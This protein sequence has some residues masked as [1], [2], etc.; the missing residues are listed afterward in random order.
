M[1]LFQ[2]TLVTSALP[3]A[4]GY[5][6]LGHVAG[7][8]LPAD[9]YTRFL[10]ATGQ[11]VIHISGS[12]EHGVA[13]MIS[14]EEEKSTPQAIVDKYHTA[15]A[16]A[17]AGLGIAFDMYGRT[18]WP[19]H[20]QSAQEFFLALHQQ[21]YLVEKEEEQFYD[22][23][24]AMFLPDRYVEGTCPVCGALGARGDQCDNC[25]STYNQTELKNPISKLTGK[26]PELRTTRHFYFSLGK[27]QQRLEEYVEGHSHDWRDHVLQQS[28]SW[29][30]QGLG[31]RAITR[32]LSWGIDVPLAGYDGKKLYVW[33][34]APFGYITNTKVLMESRGD[35]NGWRRWWQSPDTRYVAFIGKD[36]IWFHTLMFPAMLMGWNDQQREQY[37]LPNNVPA[38]NFLNL[39][40]NKFSKSRKWGID[41]QDYLAQ[42]P[43]DPLRYTLAANLPENKDADFTWRE[44]Q[45]R[46]NNELA[47]ILGNFVNRTLQFSARYFDGAVPPLSP[48]SAKEE[49]LLSLLNED[50]RRIAADGRTDEEA[51]EELSTKYLNYL[52]RND[53]VMLVALARAP[54]RI[55][56]LYSA[57]RFRDA[58]LETMNVARAANKY[59]N[60]SEPWKTRKDNPER[61]ATSLNICLQVVRSLAVLFRPIIP[62]TSDQIFGL[63]NVPP[64]ENDWYS[65][66]TLAIPTTAPLAEPV[67]LFSKV[68][69]AVVEA[70]VAKLGAAAESSGEKQPIHVELKPEVTIEDVMKLDLR[71]AT[72]LAAERVKKSEKLLK[73]Q[74]RIGDLQRQILA[75]IGKVYQPEELVGKKIV[76]V[77]NLKPAKLMGQESQGMLFAANSPDD[78]PT[79]VT[80]LHPDDVDDGFIVR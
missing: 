67:I 58:A 69:D 39:E 29:L 47:D 3:Y 14:A 68:E 37:I 2:R 49:S 45:A 10:R 71:V 12:D 59:F 66:G 55:A 60:D 51:I 5:I 23:E 57:F 6:H 42:F 46:T 62:F 13:I 24:A 72:V 1:S 48:D 43:A 4:N 28:R 41:L 21:G 44:Y 78:V 40:G 35:A 33:F 61:C 19:E 9:I 53:A 8:Y 34:D 77:A 38:C 54:H 76:V 25:S 17:F 65:A 26:T 30:K 20:H 16:A 64:T 52:T 80:V 22:P 73:L 56:D 18:T 63:L 31:D 15:N 7:A 11:E 36:N 75:G 74:I 32:D 27:F 70:Q 50:L 79:I